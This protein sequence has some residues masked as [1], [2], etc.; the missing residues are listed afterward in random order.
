MSQ[1]S[2]LLA[3]FREEWQRNARLRAGLFIVIGILALYAYLLMGDL[4]AAWKE[5]YGEET[6]RLQK[7][8]ALSGQTVWLQRAEQAKALRETLE[9]Q[10]PKAQTSG[11]AQAAFQTKLREIAAPYGEAVRLQVSAPSADDKL[12]GLWRVPATMDGNL[13]IRQVQQLL[14]DIESQ[15]VLITIETLS[16]S[17]RQNPRFNIAVQ[18]YYRLPAGNPPPSGG[19]NAP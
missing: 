13:P 1:L 7:I 10:I 5:A 12:P 19:S 4:K 14:N 18:A 8:H 3:Q 2:A 15:P 6:V 17:N 11:L 9:A 16:I